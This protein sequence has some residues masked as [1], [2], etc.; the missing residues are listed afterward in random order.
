M[1]IKADDDTAKGRFA[2][3]THVAGAPDSFVLDFAFVQGPVGWL[4]AR[5]MVSPAHAKRIHNL[6]GDALSRY[7]S[8]FG[9]IDPGP[10]LQ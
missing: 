3:L 6:L 7:E 8:R 10:T 4:L 5:I 1:Q 2:N 9:K